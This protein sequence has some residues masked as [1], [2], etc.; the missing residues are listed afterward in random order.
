V[1]LSPA[2][3]TKSSVHKDSDEIDLDLKLSLGGPKRLVLEYVKSAGATE[4]LRFGK[5]CDYLPNPPG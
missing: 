3:E 5:D 2:Y 1:Q 4:L